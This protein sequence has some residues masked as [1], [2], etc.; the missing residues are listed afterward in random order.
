MP[1]IQKKAMR[2]SLVKEAREYVEKHFKAGCN[3]ARF[4][5]DPECRFLLPDIEEYDHEKVQSTIQGA[6]SDEKKK[7]RLE[8]LVNKSFVSKMLDIIREKGLKDPDVYRA[9][10]IDRRLYSKMISN[11]LY[12]PSKDT[13]VAICLALQLSLKEANDML[14]RA[15]YVL[16]H[17]SKRDIIIEYLFVTKHYN[18]TDANY[19]LHSLEERPLGREPSDKGPIRFF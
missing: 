7:K 1:L 9:A 10:Q 5:R 19:I 4:D 11:R 16:S 14:S 3:N 6:E 13:C 18:V 12:A 8:E 17:S 15:G 2:V